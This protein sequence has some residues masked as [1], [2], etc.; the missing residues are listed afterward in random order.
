MDSKRNFDVIVIG[1]GIMGLCV[2]YYLIKN[3]LSVLVIDKD[4]INNSTS[5]ACNGN[6]IVGN[7]NPDSLSRFLL[8]S[9]H[10][11]LEL[12]QILNEKFEF[13]QKGSLLII[14]EEFYLNEVKYLFEEQFKIGIKLEFM[15]KSYINKNI[16]IN[17]GAGEFG[18]LFSAIDS[19]INPHLFCF[20]LKNYIERKKG[21]FS[22]YEEVVKITKSK[23]KGFKIETKKNIYFSDYLVNCAGYFAPTISKMLNESIPIIKNKGCILVTEALDEIL[24]LIFL[25]WKDISYDKSASLIKKINNKNK[26]Y[27]F[28][29]EQTKSGNILLGKS[30]E[31]V[32]EISDI[33]VDTIKGIANLAVSYLPIL[34]C[35]KIIRSYQGIRPVTPDNLPIIGESSENE[36]FYYATGHGGFGISMAPITGKII[37]NI[38]TK[39]GDTFD[40]SLFAPKRFLRQE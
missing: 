11:Y 14:N 18:G 12:N 10:E 9:L 3:K 37:S 13:N 40:I 15:P 20:S 36:G 39:G 38:I 32:E 34:N 17:L 4:F 35:I 23:K 1:A 27:N 22:L 6:I 7:R 28:I 31:I 2:A 5:G 33:S 24:P 21:I 16:I 8:Q 26:K 30:E 29:A 25:D 19:S